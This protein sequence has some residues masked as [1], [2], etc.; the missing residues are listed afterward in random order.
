MKLLDFVKREQE[1]TPGKILQLVPRSA[2]QNLPD[3]LEDQ[4]PSA[5]AKYQQESVIEMNGLVLVI[6]MLRVASCLT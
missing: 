4:D 5:S 1:Q 3:T 2:A 6:V